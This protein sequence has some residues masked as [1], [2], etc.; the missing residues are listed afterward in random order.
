M[1]GG[2]VV[3]HRV[4]SRFRGQATQ[5]AGLEL[6]KKVDGVSQMLVLGSRRGQI[7]KAKL[8]RTEE[9]LTYGY[10]ALEQDSFPLSCADWA[11][12]KDAPRYI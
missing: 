7:P 8:V 12:T 11:R 3:V 1:N 10:L 5:T 2:I 9:V 6:L 4:V